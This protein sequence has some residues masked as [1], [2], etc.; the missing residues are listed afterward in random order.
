MDTKSLA[1]APRN[2]CLKYCFWTLSIVQY[3]WV[4]FVGDRVGESY[5]VGSIKE[6]NLTLGTVSEAGSFSQ[7]HSS[8][9]ENRSNFQNVVFFIIVDYE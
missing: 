9:D 7:T 5:T 2:R 4:S 3:G 8:E 1:F 6:S